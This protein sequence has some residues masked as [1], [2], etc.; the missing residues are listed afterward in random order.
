MK[1]HAGSEYVSVVSRHRYRQD[2]WR[3]LL[4]RSMPLRSITSLVLNRDV[5]RRTSSRRNRMEEPAGNMRWDV[6]GFGRI[7]Y[8]RAF[9]VES[10]PDPNTKTT[11]IDRYRG[12]GSP[13]PV[14]LAQL[15]VWGR[16][17]LLCAA[18][19]DDDESRYIRSELLT[20]DIDTRYTYS[21]STA[22][23][24]TAFLVVEK[25]S[26]KRT[27]VLDRS[28]APMSVKDLPFQE[29]EQSRMLLLDGWDAEANIHSAKRA[30]EAGVKV[31]MDL[32][33]VRPAM[34]DQLSHID[35]AVASLNF[36]KEYYPEAD[37]FE[38]T[39][40]LRDTGPE[41]AMITN[42]SG[43]VVV[44]WGDR[45]EWMPSYP[46]ETVIDTTGAGDVFHAGLVHGILER[47]DI[48]R[49]VQWAASAASLSVQA[50]GARGRLPSTEEVEARIARGDRVFPTP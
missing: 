24:P 4:L 2:G 41:V 3:I 49:C 5:C 27:V 22:Q 12:F 33:N 10:Y 13:V 9:L 29:F 23:T 11:S 28:L 50:M 32:G 43:G 6:S 25:S 21:D 38:A 20:Y 34:Q 42:G 46:A 37:L 36:A 26:G 39:R 17:T 18:M 14:A 16:S 31:M 48:P 19:G 8:D 15:S 1:A 45:V 35:W 40:R 47:W 44:S 30:R 7:C